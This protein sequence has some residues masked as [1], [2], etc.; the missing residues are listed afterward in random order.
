M[1]DELLGHEKGALTGAAFRKKGKFELAHGSI[2]FFDEIGEMDLQSQGTVVRI[3]QEKKLQRIGGGRT[4]SIDIRVIASTSKDLS[5]EIEA[6]RFREDLFYMLNVIPIQVPALRDRSE[7][8]PDLIRYFL[9]Q[10]AEKNH[11]APKTFTPEAIESLQQYSWPG[12]VRELKNFLERLD[13]FFKNQLIGAKDIPSPYSPSP[14]GQAPTETSLFKVDRLE[15][16]KALFEYEFIRRKLAENDNHIATTAKAI[17]ADKAFV[18]KI[19]QKI[20]TA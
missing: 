12:N 18:Q 8:L 5:K 16:A 11:T 2:L 14:D 13:I 9:A 4:L 15:K 19:A 20:K 1:A 17:G 10:L 3:L 6:G 7:D